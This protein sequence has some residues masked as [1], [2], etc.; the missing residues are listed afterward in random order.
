MKNFLITSV[1]L[2]TFFGSITANSKE[3]KSL[4]LNKKSTKSLTE[5]KADRD[6]I[7]FCYLAHVD[8]SPPDMGGNTTTTE[9]YHCTW[10]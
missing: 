4:T 10:Y 1:L 5:A 3:I 7:W 6:D 8:Q 9:T 2:L